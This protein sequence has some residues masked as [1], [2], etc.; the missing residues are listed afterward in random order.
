MKKQLCVMA[1][2]LLTIG[3]GLAIGADSPGSVILRM[4]T[5]ISGL[6]GNYLEDG[7]IWRYFETWQTE[8]VQKDGGSRVRVDP[9]DPYSAF[10]ANKAWQ[11]DGR[12]RA[13][14]AGNAKAQEIAIKE[15]AKIKG[16][17]FPAT[18]W[19]NPDFDDSAWPRTITPS[20]MSYRSLALICLRGKFMVNNPAAVTELNL[21][22]SIQGGAVVY[23]NGKEVGRLGLPAGK[24]DNDTLA[25]AYPDE[26]FFTSAG[27]PIK[28]DFSGGQ[29]NAD[30]M[31]MGEKEFVSK[32]KD[33]D[34]Q[35]R[36]AK[37]FRKSHLKI[38]GIALRKGVNV[39]A[40]EAHRAP[41]AAGMFT[42]LFPKVT[43]YDLTDRYLIMWNRASIEELTLTTPA[44]S[45]A[46]TPNTSRPAAIQCWNL[47][48]SEEVH[49]FLYGDPNETC[50]PIRLCGA[51][52]GAFSGQVVVSAKAPIKGL[53][54]T[55][56][57]L[58]GAAGSI[59][60]S[61]MRVRYARF[62]DKNNGIGLSAFGFTA[63]EEAPPASVPLLAYRM[64]AER[65]A[66]TQPIWL[67]VQVPKDAKAGDYTGTLTVSAEGLP[68]T[69]VSVQL[70]VSNWTLPDPQ[71][72]QAYMALVES[73]DS[74][75]MRYN[76]PMWSEEH[77]KLIDQC[78]QVLGLISTKDLT[79]PLTRRTHFGNEQCMLSFEKQAGGSYKPRLE[80]LERYI[81]TAVK[82]VGKIPTLCFFI[83]ERDANG[84][85]M[86][87]E[88]DPATKTLKDGTAPAWG[89][90]DAQ[91]FWRPVFEGI[92]KILAKHGMEKSMALGYHE[93]GTDG[94]WASPAC[95][96]DA[97]AM[98]PEARWTRLGHMFNCRPMDPSLSQTLEKG[99]GNNP[100]G[101]VALVI[102]GSA[103]IHWDPDTDR[104][105]FGWLN[106]YPVIGYPRELT[107]RLRDWRMAAEKMLLAG[108]PKPQGSWGM[109]DICGMF[110][111][112]KF[113]GTK[114]LG[115]MGADFFPVLAGGAGA[116]KPICG[117]YDVKDS[118]RLWYTVGL[119]GSL[120]QI[121]GEGQ[122]GPVSSPV[123][124]N[125]REGLEEQEAFIFCENAILKK[126]LGGDLAARCKKVCD[127]HIRFLRYRC[128]F[129][130]FG[131]AKASACAH[132]VFNPDET[133]EYARKLYDMAVEVSKAA[134]G[135]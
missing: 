28:C 38:P 134:G 75:A 92:R 24:I 66:A 111:R 56:T 12:G 23:L 43:G 102:G 54:A 107:I 103:S 10:D 77:W 115:P 67:T 85:P 130:N 84:C 105:F 4:N 41:A 89:T 101:R 90:P 124:E 133:R 19:M 94:P 91:K 52:N 128:E 48:V 121:V 113:L 45:G 60:A 26:A 15:A 82:Y 5:A 30:T 73:P 80:I 29:A 86:I 25:D 83:V 59:P 129:S 21:D 64:A 78:F 20:R 16:S 116:A 70:R 100:W 47:P 135:Q 131:V 120:T 34:L 31:L 13:G 74:L 123:V 39:L 14:Q 96:A 106:P 55:V 27:C 46:I 79:I 132:I 88:Y 95:L 44:G 63:L 119:N 71:D 3:A 33:A 2:F 9:V 53:K 58:K 40:I 109:C 50:A 37:R 11:E 112:D 62:V 7:T 61:A 114:G 117:R 36:Y 6:Y 18:G 110:G 127:D 1:G 108:L 17:D 93:N 69:D 65:Q 22:L 81:D 57:E 72:Y 97:V 49:P 8:V 104:S 126:K 125:L 122:N 68:A 99:P 118:S 98:V 51:R 35:A 42:R 76:V 32:E 87:S